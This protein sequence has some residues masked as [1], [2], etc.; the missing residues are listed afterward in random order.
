MSTGVVRGREELF[1]AHLLAGMNFSTQAVAL[2]HR[3]ATSA[4]AAA[5]IALDRVPPAEPGVVATHFLRHVVRER[6]LDADAGR[7]LRAL[8]NSAV[9][10]DTG[11]VVPTEHA[12]AAIADATVVVDAVD[13]WLTGSEFV[14][15]ARAAVP[16]AGGPP[17][18]RRR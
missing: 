8:H 6:G 10:A 2:A 4:A 18:R 15:I 5:I 9:L 3:A 12:A 7:A 13:A 14:G 11:A 1:A 16:R 17:P